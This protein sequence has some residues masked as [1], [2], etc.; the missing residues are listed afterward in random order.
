MI[1]FV[2]FRKKYPIL[3]ENVD[4]DVRKSYRGGFTYVNDTWQEK[5]VGHGMSLRRETVYILHACVRRI[6]YRTDSVYYLKESMRRIVHIRY[7]FN[8]LLVVFDLKK[9][10][11]SI[12]SD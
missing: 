11:D 12:S 10:E 5:E 1:T 9:G 2:G 8:H 7:I 6:L 4:A 3:P